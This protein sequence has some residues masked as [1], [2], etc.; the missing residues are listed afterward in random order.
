LV[1][2]GSDSHLFDPV[3]RNYAPTFTTSSRRRTFSIIQG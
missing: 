1:T 2:F 3:S